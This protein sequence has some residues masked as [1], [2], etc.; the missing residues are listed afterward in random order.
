MVS[1]DFYGDKDGVLRDF[2][3]HASSTVREDFT[4]S[5]SG[6]DDVLDVFEPRLGFAIAIKSS[7][8]F[9]YLC[10]INPEML[11]GSSEVACMLL[12]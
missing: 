10:T 3:L 6:M 11:C 2:G 1:F 4:C 12:V 5:V 7:C 8:S 9:G